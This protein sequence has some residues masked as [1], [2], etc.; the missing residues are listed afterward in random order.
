MLRG[1][2]AF[3]CVMWLGVEWIGLDR[4]IVALHCVAFGCVARRG[5]A[6]VE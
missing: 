2:I 1:V 6:G 4:C 3:R 5:S